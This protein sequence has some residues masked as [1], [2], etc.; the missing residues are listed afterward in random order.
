M[1]PTEVPSRRM[2]QKVFNRGKEGRTSEKQHERKLILQQSEMRACPTV[3]QWK[4]RT[5]M[6][7][8]STIR[9]FRFITFQPSVVQS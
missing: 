2:I 9:N 5:V 4:P 1:L 8:P 3:A 6:P 7:F